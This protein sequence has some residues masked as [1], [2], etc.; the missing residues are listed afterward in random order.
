MH[1]LQSVVVLA[2]IAL[3]A[4]SSRVSANTV[5]EEVSSAQLMARSKAASTFGAIYVDDQGR[6]YTSAMT[7]TVPD[8]Y[9]VPTNPIAAV[10][11]N[12]LAKITSKKHS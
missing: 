1:L 2:S 6:S 11:S 12:L 5:D 3:V 8:T 9:A 7:A 10:A 4:C